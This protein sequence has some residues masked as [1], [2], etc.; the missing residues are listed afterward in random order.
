MLVRVRERVRWRRAERL[1][2]DVLTPTPP[3]AG[4]RRAVRSS[5]SRTLT[6][7]ASPTVVSGEQQV[8]V[9]EWPEEQTHQWCWLAMVRRAIQR[10]P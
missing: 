10:A 2:P 6:T 3:I 7:P 9:L 4:A 1:G 5:A 8:V